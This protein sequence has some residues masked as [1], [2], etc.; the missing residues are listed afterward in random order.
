MKVISH[1]KYFAQK[2][3]WLMFYLHLGPGF[4]LK[5]YFPENLIYL[6]HFLSQGNLISIPSIKFSL[7]FKSTFHFTL[8]TIKDLYFIEIID[9]P[10]AFCTI[11]IKHSKHAIFTLK[12]SVYTPYYLDVTSA[13]PSGHRR[14]PTTPLPIPSPALL[15]YHRDSLQVSDPSNF[16]FPHP[17]IITRSAGELK[18]RRRSA[19]PSTRRYR[20][21]QP[22][23]RAPAAPHHPVEPF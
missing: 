18:L 5:A 13:A 17:S 2:T 4:Y 3:L 16:T 7:G 14:Q 21:P 12:F 11:H 23:P 10:L 19:S 20:A 6:L 22:Q 9:I 15:E 1:I 8:F